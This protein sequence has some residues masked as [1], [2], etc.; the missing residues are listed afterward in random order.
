MQKFSD[1]I[2]HITVTL[3]EC[4][5]CGF[6]FNITAFLGAALHPVLA[7]LIFPAVYLFVQLIF[8]IRRSKSGS[9]YLS[10]VLTIVFAALVFMFGRKPLF[11]HVFSAVNQNGADSMGVIV[12]VM[13]N[14]AALNVAIILSFIAKLKNKKATR[15]VA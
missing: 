8:F 12:A 1:R 15:T 5:L 7:F 13:L 11:Y 9:Y 4:L 3:F 14:A 10:V 6:L 2:L